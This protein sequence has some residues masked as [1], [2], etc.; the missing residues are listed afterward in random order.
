[1]ARRS[2]TFLMSDSGPFGEAQQHVGEVDV[3]HLIAAAD[4]VDLAALPAFDD[5]VDAAAMVHDV[6]PV[7]DVEPRAVQRNRNVVERI[8]NEERDRFFRGNWNGP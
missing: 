4:V 5:G 6:Q 8:G 7:A 2:C 3:A 1:M